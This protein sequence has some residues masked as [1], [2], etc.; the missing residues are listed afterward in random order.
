[1]SINKTPMTTSNTCSKN[2]TA[3]PMVS[4]MGK[5]T[6]NKSGITMNAVWEP[7]GGSMTSRIGTQWL[8]GLEEKT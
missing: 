6:L 3:S 2:P 5:S 4:N 8:R 7:A 1:M